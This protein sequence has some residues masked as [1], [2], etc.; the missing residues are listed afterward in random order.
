[1]SGQES[2]RFRWGSVL[3]VRGLI[4]GA[5]RSRIINSNYARWVFGGTKPG[6]EVFGEVQRWWTRVV[7]K[8]NAVFNG[9]L[10]NEHQLN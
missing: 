6:F 3:L 10:S 7:F 4:V 1:M 9:I 5:G 8:G 2:P